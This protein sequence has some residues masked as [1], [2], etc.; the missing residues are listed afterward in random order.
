MKN[1]T[2]AFFATLSLFVMG[3]FDS[4]DSSRPRALRVAEL[5]LL[6]FLLRLIPYNSDRLKPFIA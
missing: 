1:L 6:H 3:G 4:I 5:S 2:A